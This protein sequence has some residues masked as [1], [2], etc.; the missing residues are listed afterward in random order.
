MVAVDGAE[1]PPHPSAAVTADVQ[2]SP[3]RMRAL[4]GIA[5]AA[6][7]WWSPAATLAGEAM[8]QADQPDHALV[9]GLTATQLA[10]AAAVGAGAGLAGALASGN[11]IAGASLGVGTL[12]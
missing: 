12:T 2:R 5:L 8:T 10:V 9:V 11:L 3:R 6:A 7:L 4:L 1:D